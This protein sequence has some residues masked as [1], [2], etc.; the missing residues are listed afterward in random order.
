MSTPA[1]SASSSRTSD[2]PSTRKSRSHA[3]SPRKTR[4]A[5]R[6][7]RATDGLESE[8]EL[9]REV[10]T[11]SETGDDL[12]SIDSDSDSDTEPVSEGAVADGRSRPLTPS[13]S[14][15]P[16][17][18]NKELP[19]RIDDTPQPFFTQPTTWGDMVMEEN[20]HGAAELPVIDFAD[21]HGDAIPS[22]HASRPLSR[23]A[24]RQLDEPRDR[25]PQS[26]ACEDGKNDVDRRPSTPRRSRS[27]TS[28]R[29][30]GQ[31]ARQVYQQRLET[32][33]S[34]VPTVGGFWGH[35]ERLLD[36]E[37]RSLSGWWRGRWQSR[38]RGRGFSLRVRGGHSQSPSPHDADVSTLTPE[39]PPIERTWTHDGFEEMKRREEQRRALQQQPQANQTRGVRGAR[40]GFAAGRGGRV[41]PTRGGL[42]S[43]PARSNIPLA[44]GRVWFT[45]KPD[46]MWTKQQ[47]AFLFFDSSTKPRRGQR[48]SYKVKLPGSAAHSVPALADA[49]KK[50]SQPK[51]QVLDTNAIAYIIRI[52]KTTPAEKAI[53]SLTTVEEASLE[54]I[55]TV[56]PNLV[57]PIPIPMPHAVSG[58]STIPDNASSVD[59][60][61][62]NV[63]LSEQPSQLVR[64]STESQV[65]DQATNE[66]TIQTPSSEQ[67]PT[68]RLSTSSDQRP[69]L[70]PLQTVFTPP[71]VAHPSPAYGPAYSYGPS[72]PPGVALNA[73][74][75]PYEL[76]TGRPVYLAATPM[77]TPRPMV[78]SH[79]TPGAV[80]FIPSHMHHSSISP[81]F[82]SQGSSHTPPMNGFIDP[83]TETPLFSLP[84]QTRISIRAPSDESDGKGPRKGQLRQPGTGTRTPTVSSPPQALDP[85]SQTYYPSL[86]RPSETAA[87]PLYNGAGSRDGQAINGD[88]NGQQ[89]Q[90][91]HMVSYPPYQPY[92]YPGSYGYYP[93]M[94]MS[95]VGQYDMYSSDPRGAQG[96]VYY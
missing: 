10:G 9:V 44:Q 28:K 68:K 30:S 89:R 12:S 38:G 58:P 24:K 15:S 63:L 77:Y 2:K 82:M 21:F 61:Q 59:Q 96:S 64:D 71:P 25:S 91:P 75:V 40:G 47:E 54:E 1:T 57:T 87:S 31:S 35:D 39:L 43:S 3:S 55:F 27:L 20:A 51:S 88:I 52:P 70:P 72:L 22:S 53:E 33:P 46:R 41:G 80:P 62:G 8:D 76:A 4:V 73:H 29:P 85:S 18:H 69:T 36:K 32:D 34:F 6:R 14:D 11:D 42:V 92:Y 56:R 94:D 65:L 17:S 74:G 37:L 60:E 86:T 83:T 5:R 13:T 78:P 16:H 19:T 23:K 90:D 50:R 66:E 81:D 93:Y 45:M 67:S 95:Q 79:L 84:R 26:E 48:L 49:E 7:G